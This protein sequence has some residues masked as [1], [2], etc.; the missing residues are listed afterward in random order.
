MKQSSKIIGELIGEH[1]RVCYDLTSINM[2]EEVV[3]KK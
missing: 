3:V 2:I 1:T